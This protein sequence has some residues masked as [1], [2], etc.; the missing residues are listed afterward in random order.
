[1][2]KVYSSREIIRQLMDDGWYE[3]SEIE[4]GMNDGD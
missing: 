2:S 4:G 1:M 3:A